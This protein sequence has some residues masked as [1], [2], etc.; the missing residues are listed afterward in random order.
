MARPLREVIP[1]AFWRDLRDQGLVNPA[2]PLP[3]K[4]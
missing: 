2:A 3:I 4:G 1:A